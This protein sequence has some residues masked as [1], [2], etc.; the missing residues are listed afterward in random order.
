LPNKTNQSQSLAFPKFDR[1]T[2]R[3]EITLKR[4]IWLPKII[5]W[6]P[7]NTYKSGYVDIMEGITP[8]GALRLADECEGYYGFFEN[9]TINAR[10]IL[11]NLEAIPLPTTNTVNPNINIKE[12]LESGEIPGKIT[13]GASSGNTEKE[14]DSGKSL[15]DNKPKNYEP[16]KP[17]YYCK[18]NHWHS[19]CPEKP[20]TLANKKSNGSSSTFNTKRKGSESDKYTI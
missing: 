10:K 9:G 4:S 14:N 8:T 2:G 13:H 5:Y 16:P 1:P 6:F 17:C 15:E 20:L 19:D 18:G 11:Q 3:G 12:S 7:N